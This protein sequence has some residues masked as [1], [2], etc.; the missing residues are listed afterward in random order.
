MTKKEAQRVY[1]V[2][3]LKKLIDLLEQ[4]L[5]EA[6]RTNAYLKVILGNEMVDTQGDE[7][8]RG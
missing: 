8:W 6:K 5:I 1:D 7:K 4:L 3:D 2:N